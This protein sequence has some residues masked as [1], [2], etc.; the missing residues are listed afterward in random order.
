MQTLLIASQKGGAGKST[1]ARN[2]AVAAA[3]EGKTVLMLD[4][5]PQ[6]SLRAWWG[7]RKE[8]DILMLEKDP[9]PSGLSA[10]LREAHRHEVDLVVIDTPP[11][12]AT[13]LP[14]AMRLADLVLVP[15]RPSPTDLRAVSA[16]LEAAR[17]SNSPFVFILSQTHPRA[18]VVQESARLLAPHGRIAPANLTSRVSHAES[19]AVGR[20]ALETKDKR[21]ADEVAQTWAYVKGLLL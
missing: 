20:A 10:T 8:T 18:R 19:D 1:L 11:S 5:D 17:S 15:I 6:M 9:T 16:T 14:A 12:N 21:A 3:Q 2:L 7:D 4:L 13:W